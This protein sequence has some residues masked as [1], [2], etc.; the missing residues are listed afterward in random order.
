MTIESGNST[1]VVTPYLVHLPMDC[2]YNAW[3]LKDDVTPVQFQ[4]HWRIIEFLKPRTA[5]SC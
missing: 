1:V 3:H 2:V 4:S 5:A